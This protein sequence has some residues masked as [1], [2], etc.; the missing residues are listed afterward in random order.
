MD[1]KALL[2]SYIPAHKYALLCAREYDALEDAVLKSPKMDG[3][4][5]TQSI[6]GLEYEAAR[7]EAA[8]KKLD[9][10]RTESLKLL[11][12]IENLIDSL[13]DFDQ[14]QIIRM[15][16]IIGADARSCRKMPW[17]EVAKETNWCRAQVY[18]IHGM[19]LEVLRRK[20]DSQRDH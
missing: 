3:M 8:R 14:K 1:V 2:E 17:D 12:E 10:A 15:R 20:Y 5:R 4:P 19:A 11:E 18:K 16:Y 7:R 6:H 13:D 9:K